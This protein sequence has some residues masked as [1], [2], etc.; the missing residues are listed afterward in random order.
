MSNLID[1]K[2]SGIT[3]INNTVSSVAIFALAQRV[4]Y[5]L[6]KNR[7]KYHKIWNGK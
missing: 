1:K 5:K 6:K 4:E 2:R 7:E 3:N